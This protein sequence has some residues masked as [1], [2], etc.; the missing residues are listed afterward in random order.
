MKTN[1]TSPGMDLVTSDL[2]GIKEGIE[3]RIEFLRTTNVF[4]K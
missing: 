3:V 4:K 1:T 2:L